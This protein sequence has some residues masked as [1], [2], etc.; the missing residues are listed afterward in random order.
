VQIEA[1]S[2]FVQAG[3]AFFLLLAAAYSQG[4]LIFLRYAPQPFGPHQWTIPGEKP[5]P[6]KANIEL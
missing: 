5:Y 6:D 2:V 4:L 3:T 1:V